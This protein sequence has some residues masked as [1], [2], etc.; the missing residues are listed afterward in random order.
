MVP[1]SSLFCVKWSGEPGGSRTCDHRIKSAML[2]Q[3]SYR[4]IPAW[5]FIL[6][7]A[8]CVIMVLVTQIPLIGMELADIEAALGAGQPKFRARQ[9]YEALYRQ[10][11]AA[12]ENITNFPKPLREQLG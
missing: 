6:T 12:L 3:L 5:H 7:H 4:P 1:V 9:L 10:R 2:Y 11:V 8:L